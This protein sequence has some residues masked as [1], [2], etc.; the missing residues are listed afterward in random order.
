MAILD[1]VISNSFIC[2]IDV[3]FDGSLSP[4]TI[5]GWQ[6]FSNSIIENGSF[7]KLYATFPSVN[8]AEESEP[9]AAGT[10]Y[11]QKVVFSFPEKDA[12]RS[13]RIAL[14]HQLKFIRLYFA[15]G[16]VILIGRNDFTQNAPPKIKY[17][18]NGNN[19][20]FEVST[21]SIMPSGFTP[22]PNAFG[23]PTLI[24]FSLIP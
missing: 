7:D 22:R 6:P 21:E 2:G 8:F 11:N 1:K 19:A 16:L 15:D 9:S 23:L 12:Q 4:S 14:L 20:Q 13:E 3:C 5:A 17:G 10:V 18:S 24:P